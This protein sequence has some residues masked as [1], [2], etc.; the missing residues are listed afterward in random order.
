[1]AKLKDLNKIAAM[2]TRHMAAIGLIIVR[3]FSTV[4][5]L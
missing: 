2:Y 5:A 4:S 1:M 3:Q